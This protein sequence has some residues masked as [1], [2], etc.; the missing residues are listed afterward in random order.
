MLLH[1]HATRISQGA[2]AGSHII[3]VACY[4]AV[5][6]LAEQTTGTI[7]GEVDRGILVD[8]R[9]HTADAVVG[10]FVACA[11]GISLG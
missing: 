1:L 10:I 11:I 5:E 3:T 2:L 9:K 6:R 4:F 7:V 8:S